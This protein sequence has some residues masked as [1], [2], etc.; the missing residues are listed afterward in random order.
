MQL[1]TRPAPDPAHEAALTLQLVE[2]IAEKVRTLTERVAF[3][4]GN[5]LTQTFG[6][7]WSRSGG[8][9]AAS[10][11]E[12]FSGTEL[13]CSEAPGGALGEGR[14]VGRRAWREARLPAG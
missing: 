14:P 6:M 2:A 1:H 10:E 3:S 11:S 8:I 5:A 9:S 12:C 7:G 4:T 13:S